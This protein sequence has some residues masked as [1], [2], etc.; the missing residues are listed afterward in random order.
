M[1]ENGMSA[2]Q[3]MWFINIELWSES[4]HRSVEM[5]TQAATGREALIDAI[6]RVELK[7]GELFHTVHIGKPAGEGF[8]LDEDGKMRDDWLLA[9]DD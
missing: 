1:S 2:P 8:C 5:K 7:E 9:S 3:A 6:S 4:G